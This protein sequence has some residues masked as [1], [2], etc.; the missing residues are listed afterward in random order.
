MKI[1]MPKIQIL[2]IAALL[3]FNFI[4]PADLEAQVAVT[5]TSGTTSGSYATVKAAFDKINDGTHKGDVAIKLSA[6]TTETA[7]ASLN[8]SGS[9]SA[10]YTGVTIYPTASGVVVSGD[11][12]GPLI[13]L[14]GA[15]YVTIDGR[16][17]LSGSS[18][19]LTLINSSTSSA[20]Y[21]S[22]VYI[23][24]DAIGNVLTYCN[25][26]GSSL[27]TTAGIVCFGNGS[28][29]GNDNNMVSSCNITNN[30]GSRPV[31]A[32]FSSSVSGLSSQNAITT[33]NFYD[34]FNS[35]NSSCGINIGTGN[36]DWSIY[37]NS[38]Y[39]TGTLAPSA[40]V[41]YYG[42]Y[43]NYSSGTL[44]N[45][46]SNYIGGS[47]AACGG[48]AFTK[49]STNN[50]VFY[51]IYINAGGSSSSDWSNVNGNTIKNITWSNSGNASFYGIYAVSA[52]LN[53][54]T[55]GGGNVIGS[56][57]GNG[58]ITY[59]AGADQGSIYGISFSG[60]NVMS[61]AGN[62]VGAITANASA[63]VSTNLYGIY[64]GGSNTVTGNSISGNTIVN[65]LSNSTGSGTLVDGIYVS[66]GKNSIT[67]NTISSLTNA[68]S[69]N[70][71]STHLMSAGGIVVYNST[72]AAQTITGNTIHGISST[73]YDFPGS[74]A[75]IYYSGPSNSGTVSGNFIYDISVTGGGSSGNVYGIKTDA[76]PATWANN[77]ISLSSNTR[78]YLYGFYDNGGSGN[79]LSMYFNTIYFAVTAS[80]LQR[81]V[82]YYSANNSNTR[83]I[84]N[85]IFFNPRS[86]NTSGIKQYGVYYQATGSL[87]TD[88]NDYLVTGSY[89]NVGY[90]SGADQATLGDLQTATGQESHSVTTNPDFLNGGSST[91]SDY[92]PQATLAGVNGTG[93]TTDYFNLARASTPC[94]GAV[95]GQGV[96]T[97]TGGTSTNWSATANWSGNKVPLVG[98]NVTI[99]SGTTYS[100]HVTTAPSSYSECNNLTIQSGA[101]LTIDAGKALSVYGTLTNSTGTAG[102]VLASSGSETGILYTS[103]PGVSATVQRY[104]A[105]WTDA[106]HGWHFLSSP[107]S[108]QAISPAFTNGIAENYDF[109]AWWEPTNEWVNYKNSS[110]APT[111]NTAN[112][113]NG[114]GGSGNLIAGKGYLVAYASS[115]TKSFAGTLN[116][117]DIPVSGLTYTGTAT[118][119]GWNLL[120]NPFSCPVAW[121]AAGNTWSL[122]N[123]DANCQIWNESGASYT[124]ITPGD[125]IPESNGFM[126]RVSSTGTGS[127]TIPASSRRL[128]SP[129]WYKSGNTDEDRIVLKAVD[130]AGQTFQETVISFNPAATE[131]FDPLYDSYFLSGYA[132]AFYS[133]SRNQKYALNCLPQLS[134]SLIIPLGFIK[135]GSSDFGIELVRNIPGLSVYLTD[136]KTNKTQELS[137]DPVYLFTSATGDAPDRFQLSFVPNG[138]PEGNNSPEGI[139]SWGN[140]VYIRNQGISDLKIYDLS[141]QIVF[142]QRVS[143]Q[144]LTRIVPEIAS[145]YYIACLTGNSG[146]SLKKIQIIR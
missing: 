96:V 74:V 98:Q 71:S 134:S 61:V 43:V 131:N 9:G 39:E 11:I 124:V 101:I 85:N 36:S 114:T 117:S 145:G 42:I 10:S 83:D 58:S 126:V 92:Y 132:P 141:G 25:V 112:V 93:I 121:N 50:N 138:M 46:S 64:C 31:N 102:L 4:T 35:G 91:A 119:K 75:G 84:R 81:S 1:I 66:S 80:C 76:G 23:V 38:I 53:I 28:T 56:S 140:S 45:V 32:L 144:G 51:G 143:Q 21:T 63:A 6:G 111:W 87:T 123:I 52:Y 30:G 99:P 22:T 7:T 29:N 5:A 67:G 12:A 90:Y 97:W 118:Y 47:A 125:L 78:S 13:E 60:N 34:V 17:N 54:G 135:N 113:L 88:Y 86:G 20:A 73:S 109:Y 40:A 104:I 65:L 127:L 37:Y 57:S 128:S 72:A 142:N 103:T 3:L 120:G 77:I 105:A 79:N 94:M 33:N 24:S 15:D 115:D 108:S 8:A 59:S 130:P 137:N 48:T 62:T 26:K 68:G 136:L 122:S 95:E 69:D 18:A 82:C 19:D 106:V 139:Y 107:V 2:F 14:N 129:S 116:I 70:T 27:C 89:G 16:V 41:T 55:S 49:S 146:I 133:I 100:P 110:T 44:F